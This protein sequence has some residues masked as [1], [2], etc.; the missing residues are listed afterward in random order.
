MSREKPSL[1]A[2]A[3]ALAEFLFLSCAAL[4]VSLIVFLDHLLI[5]HRT[6]E[7]SVTELS[8]S[9]L[10]ALSAAICGIAARRHVHARG[11]LALMAGFFAVMLV[12]EQDGFFDTIR[13]GSWVYPVVL[14]AT[15]TVAYALKYH[16]TII[17][18]MVGFIRSR[19]YYPI[20]FG[21]VV[22]VI[23][24]QSFGSGRLWEL[25]MTDTY[26]RYVKSAMQEGLELFGYVFIFYGCCLN[27]NV[28]RNPE[29]RVA[30]ENT[31]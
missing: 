29:Q 26:D 19:A 22:V 28:F 27:L 7:G 21:L 5:G 17:P 9:A 11:F 10:L 15:G 25:I 30:F 3:G 18:S 20:L 4:A 2:I 8:Q 31:R 12:R 1:P 16:K 13:H 14:L 24:S 6:S 23:F